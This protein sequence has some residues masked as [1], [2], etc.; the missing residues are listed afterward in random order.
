[1]RYPCI[2]VFR[3]AYAT[4]RPRMIHMRFFGSSIGCMRGIRVA[5]GHGVGPRYEQWEIITPQILIRSHALCIP[6]FVSDSCV[7]F[8]VAM[9]VY[10]RSY[11]S[12]L[13]DRPARQPHPC[14]P[15]FSR[16]FTSLQMPIHRSFQSPPAHHN[17]TQPLNRQQ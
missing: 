12:G 2:L 17:I 9:H 4:T 13:D 15:H 11:G 16:T 3:D 14:K 6:G 1:M 5:F 7:C 10:M 8:A